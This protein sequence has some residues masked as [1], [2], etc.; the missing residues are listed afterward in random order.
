M[1][2]GYDTNNIN[3]VRYALFCA[4]AAESSH[5][6]PTQD[7]LEQHIQHANYQAAVWQR[8]LDA[9]PTTPSPHGHGWALSPDKSS[10]S[11]SWMTLPAAP[12]EVLK[13][14]RRKCRTGCETGCCSCHRHA[15][16]CTDA[17]A[18]LDCGNVSQPASI[19]EDFDEGDS[20]NE[21]SVL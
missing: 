1:L 12:E 11:I 14:T 13:T 15:L 10:L 6:P 3:A 7:A 18:C 5:L 17:C 16:P 20:D 21:I 2:Y 19:S 9:E 4:K 8:A